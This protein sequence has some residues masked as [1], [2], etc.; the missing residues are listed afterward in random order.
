MRESPKGNRSFLYRGLWR[1][2][3][4]MKGYIKPSTRHS[5]KQVFTSLLGFPCSLVARVVLLEIEALTA[6]VQKV[7]DQVPSTGLHHS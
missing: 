5:W 2:P 3:I 6:T 4:V 7:S 1:C